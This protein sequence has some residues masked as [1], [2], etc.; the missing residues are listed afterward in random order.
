MSKSID[1]YFDFS[2]PYA[3]FASTR[4]DEVASRHDA[5][6]VW[7]PF[8]LGAV[9]KVN[10]AAPLTAVPLKGEYSRH[11]WAR[12]SR[13]YSVPFHMP[14]QFPFGTVTACR[15]FY[16]VQET[17]PAGAVRLAKA[18]F[19][20]AFG[21]GRDVSTVE[22]VDAVAVAAGFDGEDIMT[23]IQSPAIKDR[24]K[25]EVEAAIG[26]GVFGAP[27]FIVGGESFWGNDRLDQVGEW[28]DR[29]GW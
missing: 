10:G 24:L 22:T 15:A 14:A 21:E 27:F 12:A 19:H 29:G 26:R 5:A 3:Y 2:S 11:D 13:R 28:L 8:L 25:H 6:V 7:R 4:V 18:L 9:F 1:F 16:H 20:A 17:D 23:G